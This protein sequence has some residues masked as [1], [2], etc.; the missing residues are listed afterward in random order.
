M[1]QTAVIDGLLVANP[2]HIS[3]AM[4]T[5]TKRQA[6]VLSVA[7]LGALAD[8]ISPAKL[9]ALVLLPAWCGLRW[10]HVIELCRKDIHNDAEV[11]YVR[12]GVTPTKRA[13]PYLNHEAEARSCCGRAAVH[14]RRCETPPRHVCR[15]S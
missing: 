5:T 1:G 4:S 15:E 11:L 2:C 10:G 3:G 14:P 12:R 8:G 9:K 13:V 7:D 6:V